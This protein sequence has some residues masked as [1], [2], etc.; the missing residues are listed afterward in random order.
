ML[1]VEQATIITAD[2]NDDGDFLDLTAF[3]AGASFSHSPC[4]C[5]DESDV[6]ASWRHHFDCNNEDE[7]N[8]PLS[9]RRPPYECH[10]DDDNDSS[11]SSSSDRRRVRFSPDHEIRTY[12]K[13]TLQDWNRLYYS[14]HELQ[15]IV[16]DYRLEQQAEKEWEQECSSLV[17]GGNAKQAPEE[18]PRGLHDNDESEKERMAGQRPGTKGV[19][20][21]EEKGS[22]DVEENQTDVGVVR[23]QTAQA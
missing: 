3:A 12:D 21:K 7:S 22:A 20:T 19:D 8:V 16:D 5:D 10:D 1:E 18:E 23:P 4:H 15:K 2:E 14:C 6:P 9:W 13:P 11:D 17:V